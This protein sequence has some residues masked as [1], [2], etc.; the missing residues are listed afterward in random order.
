MPEERFLSMQLHELLMYLCQLGVTTF[1]IAAQ[2]GVIG[3]TAAPID[4]SYLSD[5]VIML[6]FFEAAG[7]MRVSIAVTKNR[8]GAHDRSIRELSIDDSGINIGAALKDFQGIFTG[9]PY[10]MSAVTELA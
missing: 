3:N 1:L 2:N 9:T 6:R 7:C 8:G 4:A 5:A 10:L